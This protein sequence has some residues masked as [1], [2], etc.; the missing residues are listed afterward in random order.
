[1][2]SVFVN[3]YLMMKL[4]EATWVRFAVWLILG[5]LVTGIP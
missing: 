2:F 4:S 5:V 1:M 3:V